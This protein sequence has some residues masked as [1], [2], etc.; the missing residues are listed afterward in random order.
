MSFAT[1][2]PG[3][4]E[5]TALLFALSLGVVT[6][7]GGPLQAQGEPCIFIRGNV[8]DKNPDSSPVVD[9][10]DA[11][12]ILA[13][14]F[15]NRSTPPCGD[16]ADVNDNGL[17]ELSDYTYLVNF[18]FNGG[19]PPP[20]PFPEAGEDTTPEITVPDDP[21]DRFE[22]TLG[23]GEGVPNNT[24][25]SIPV[26]LSNEVPITGLTMAISYDP[27]RIRIDELITEENTLLSAQSAEYITAEAHNSTGMAY[28]A[29]LKDFA[30]P[31]AFQDG[32][33]PEIPAGE[34]QLIATLK[35]GIVIGAD[36]GFAPI[37]F[38][39]GLKV[40]SPP[41]YTPL[42]PDLHNLVMLGDTPVRPGLVSGGGID[43]RAGFIRGDANKD[44]GVDIS[45]PVYILS[46]VFQGGPIPPCLDASDAN[47]D[48][49]L[50]ISDAIWL[51]NFLF[52][53]G[54]QPSEPYP[55]AGVDPSDD[56]TES[57]GC[58]ADA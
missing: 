29:A 15:L 55:Q 8:V 7:F 37:S 51:L 14:L 43:I 9:L 58:E 18:L 39:D 33:D 5:R 28:I 31:F 25:I 27:A 1:S 38:T 20:S 16:A 6:L 4:L 32:S 48:T 46:H 54:P 40:P 11:I 22:F 49:R 35:C 57:M 34:D 17:V 42:P 10:N 12:D 19:P 3:R 45:D 21:D 24:G 41:D 36:R 47:N 44:D 52:N 50:D 53:G 2:V 56:G 26:T 13:I 30:T 23:A